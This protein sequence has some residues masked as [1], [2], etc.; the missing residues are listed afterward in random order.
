MK[1]IFSNYGLD[2]IETGSWEV[3]DVVG[4]GG[5][6]QAMWTGVQTPHAHAISFCGYSHNNDALNF[7]PNIRVYPGAPMLGYIQVPL[8]GVVDLKIAIFRRTT[9]RNTV[10]PI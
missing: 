10:T 2:T 9:G 5:E 3:S 7:C 8:C 4:L 6:W 1:K